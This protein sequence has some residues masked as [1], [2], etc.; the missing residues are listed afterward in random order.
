MS[1]NWKWHLI[2]FHLIVCVVYRVRPCPLYRVI[3]WLSKHIHSIQVLGE[4]PCEIHSCSIHLLFFCVSFFFPPP[5]KSL[6]EA[7]IQ[8]A[9][10]LLRELFPLFRSTASPLYLFESEEGLEAGV[11]LFVFDFWD[12]HEIGDKPL[13]SRR[14]GGG[15]G[16]NNVS[17]LASTPCAHSV[18]V[19]VQARWS[20]RVQARRSVKCRFFSRHICVSRYTPGC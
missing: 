6:V 1:R 7:C 10:S 2:P 13:M 20:K 11:F 8:T 18:C 14:K 15:E 9:A 12:S 5:Q 3:S 4:R 17:L 16:K 19:C